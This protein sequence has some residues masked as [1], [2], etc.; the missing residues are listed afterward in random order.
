MRVVIVF[1][2]LISLASSQNNVGK[3]QNAIGGLAGLLPNL[4]GGV[5]GGTLGLITGLVKTVAGPLVYV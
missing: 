1:A 3:Q 4:L 2:L 5:L